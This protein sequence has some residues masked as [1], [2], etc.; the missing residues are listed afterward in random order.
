MAGS[1]TGV[2]SAA[3]Q[4][5]VSIAIVTAVLGIVGGTAV[6]YYTITKRQEILN[7]KT[8]ALET[9]KAGNVYIPF[10]KPI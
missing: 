9:D 7:S 6:A 4:N 3:N 2:K 8:F 10:S 5:S 1:S